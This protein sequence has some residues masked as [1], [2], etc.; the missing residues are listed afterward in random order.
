MEICIE[1]YLA[2]KL[3]RIFVRKESEREREGETSA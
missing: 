1:T 2:S 3:A